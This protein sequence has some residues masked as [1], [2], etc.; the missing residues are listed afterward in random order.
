MHGRFTVVS[1][2]VEVRI[3]SH[4]DFIRYDHFRKII[5]KTGIWCIVSLYRLIFD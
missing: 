3:W 5:I 4:F 2:G 1:D